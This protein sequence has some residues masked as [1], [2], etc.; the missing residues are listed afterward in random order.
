MNLLQAI[1]LSLVEGITE[2][3]P[4]SSTG[5][6]ILASK[7]L[8]ITQTE[9]VKSFEIAIQLGAIFAV[10]FLYFRILIKRFNYWKKILIAFLPT[11][12]LGF[13][14]YG[15]VKHYLLGNLNVVI[16]SLLVGGIAMLVLESYFA[17]KKPKSEIINLTSKNSLFIGLWQS[18]AMIPGVSRALTTIYAGMGEGLTREAATKFSF[19][20]AIPTIAAATGLD[21]LKSSF[22]FSPSEFW[23]LLAGFGGAFLSALFTVKALI[24]FVKKHN[25]RG[26]AWYRIGLAVIFWLVFR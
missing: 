21:L 17:K 25:F 10:V 13:I 23:L 12:A 18:V 20:L 3:L 1:V 22:Q 8:G 19:L 26:F 4:I 6:L 2:F 9:F 15:F 24:S 11:G 14:F 16:F 5:H 7:L